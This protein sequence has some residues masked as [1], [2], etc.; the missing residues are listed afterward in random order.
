VEQSGQNNLVKIIIH[1]QICTFIF[2]EMLEAFDPATLVFFNSLN[3]YSAFETIIQRHLHAQ[4]PNSNS[5]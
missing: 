1:P 5:G 3:A 4:S 2:N